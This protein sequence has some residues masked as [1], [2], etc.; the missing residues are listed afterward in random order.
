M[1]GW[2]HSPFGKL[3]ERD[4]E[5]LIAR[6]AAPA[7]ADAGVSLD[8]IDGVFVGHFNAG[9]SQQEFPSSLAMQGIPEL[10]FKPALRCEN[11]C[12]SGSAAI[13]AG[14]DFI[15]SGRGRTALV[16]GVEKMT[17]VPAVDVGLSLLRASYHREE[18]GEQA[19]FA[20]VFGRIARSYF[21]RYGDQSDALA[22]I[23]AK[24]HRNGVDNPY[25]QLRKDF[26]FEF[27]R[28]LSDRNPLVAPPLKRTDCAPVSDGAAALIL[29]DRKMAA[30][31]AKAVHFRGIGQASDYLPMSRRDITYFSAGE[32]AWQAAFKT[33]GLSLGD[34]SFVET[35]DCFTIAELIEYEVMG[36]TPRGQGARAAL[37]GWTASDGRLPVNRSG[38]LKAKGHPVGATGVSMHVMAAMQLT[39]RAGDMQLPSLRYGAVYN[40]GG[41]GVANY[42]SILETLRS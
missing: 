12:A 20:G 27:C 31:L 17:S 5:S 40:M 14:I 21:E 26:G 33:S 19:G 7:I 4:V 15:R 10:R 24:N 37:E 39:G 30:G 9:F 28:T 23:A 25:A 35:H 29:A 34:V 11:A 3:A 1:V 38:G 18:A 8:D 42:V 36:L 16:V 6:V 2:A 41:S 13:Y 32:H 22:A